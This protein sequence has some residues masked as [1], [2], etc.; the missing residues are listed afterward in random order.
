MLRCYNLLCYLVFY[1]GDGG[2]V[3]LLQ[4]LTAKAGGGGRE[5]GLI[6]RAG[7]ALIKL[8]PYLST[9]SLANKTTRFES[10]VAHDS[11]SQSALLPF[12]DPVHGNQVF[13]HGNALAF[14]AFQF[15]LHLSGQITRKPPHA[16]CV[17]YN[18]S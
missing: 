18:R 7:G 14:Q 5:G 10:F 17:A 8:L 1:L 6:E 3:G 2:G 11:L 12:K 15:T 9:A 13:C 4:N 16:F